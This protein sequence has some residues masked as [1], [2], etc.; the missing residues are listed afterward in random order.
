MSILFVL[1][2]FLLIMVATYLRSHGQVPAK[3]EVWAG[4]QA[5]R[6]EREYGFAIPQGYS[7]HPGHTWVIN[8]GGENTR[9]GLDSFA[10]NLLGSIEHIDVISPNRW[11]R[12]GQKLMTIK[13]GEQSVELLSPVEGVVTAVN[14]DL[15][16]N[17]SLASRSPYKD[18]W[19]A[20]IKSPDFAINQ[21]NL[22]QGTMVAPWMQNNVTRLNSMVT[23][24]NPALAQ[25]G[26]QPISGILARVAPEVRQKIVAEFFLN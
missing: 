20:M 10:A 21:K 9:V 2:M 12:Q 4:P 11:I 8:E 7:F 22:I 15:A 23:Q 1:L 14:Q 25:D 16:D 24:L 18:G 17:P 26:G 19:V 6:M 13:S 5:P 3:A